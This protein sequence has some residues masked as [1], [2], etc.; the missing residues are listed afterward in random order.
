VL[1]QSASR[2]MASTTRPGGAGAL[3]G[4]WVTRVPAG[5]WSSHIREH[6]IQVEKTLVVLDRAPTEVE[7]IVRRMSTRNAST[8]VSAAGGRDGGPRRA[9]PFGR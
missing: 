7:R 5:C 3:A 6:T 2:F 4:I 1:D 8:T 9:R